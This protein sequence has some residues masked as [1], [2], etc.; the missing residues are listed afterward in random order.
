M[1]IKDDRSCLRE[2][3]LLTIINRSWGQAIGFIGFHAV[4]GNGEEKKTHID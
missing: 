3:R 4:M 2:W 1:K